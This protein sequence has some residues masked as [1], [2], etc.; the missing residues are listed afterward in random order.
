MFNYLI[1]PLVVAICVVYKKHCFISMLL[2]SFWEIKC[3]EFIAYL[4]RNEGGMSAKFGRAREFDPT[5]EDWEFYAE[6]MKHYLFANN[7]KE[8]KKIPVLLSTCGTATYS[9]IES[10]QPRLPRFK[11]V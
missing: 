9:L 1:V 11:I 8:A 6:Q 10:L 3:F 5:S 2:L 4:T 7:V